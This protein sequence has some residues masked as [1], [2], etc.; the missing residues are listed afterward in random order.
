MSD[1]SKLVTSTPSDPVRNLPGTY[2]DDVEGIP[3]ADLTQESSLPKG[4]DPS[5]FKL[6]PISTG[7]R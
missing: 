2:K 5:P 1:L 4:P 6:G 7:E 3:E